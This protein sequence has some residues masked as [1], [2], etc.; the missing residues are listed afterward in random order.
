[1]VFE[2]T[3]ST[4]IPEFLLG[5]SG[6]LEFSVDIH[7]LVPKNL[8]VTAWNARDFESGEPYFSQRHSDVIAVTKPFEAK[9]LSRD[10]AAEAVIINS[11]SRMWGSGSLV[12]DVA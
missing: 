7:D 8:C 2:G 3:P 11:E 4:P 9:T 5:I 6:K 10:F 12:K 1:M